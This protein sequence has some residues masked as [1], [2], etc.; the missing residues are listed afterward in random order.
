MLGRVGIRESEVWARS[1][2]VPRVRDRDGDEW[3]AD[4]GFGAGQRSG[5]LL[6]PIPFGPGGV[7]EQS[8]WGYRVETYGGR[9]GVRAAPS[10]TPFLDVRHPLARITS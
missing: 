3:H 1:H 7:Y 8:G 2:L 4:V 6:D 9:R 10:R 5:T